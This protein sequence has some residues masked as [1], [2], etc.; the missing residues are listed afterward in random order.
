MKKIGATITLILMLVSMVFSQNLTQTVRGTLI[1]EDSK[2][3]LI[4][5]NVILLDSN[6]IKGVATDEEGQFKLE[7]IPIGR[8]ALKMSY[9]GYENAIIPNIVVNSGKEVV[10]NL[11]M[12]ESAVKMDAVVITVDKNKGEALNDMAIISARSISPE[13]TSRYAGGFNDP[14]RI[15]SNFAGVTNTQDGSNDI[16]V[17]GNSPKYVQW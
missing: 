6:P 17:R 13:E 12:R 11:T 3:P 5:A 16:I 9:I 10:L 4:G 2:M 15:V 7:N 1:D 14:S 8:I